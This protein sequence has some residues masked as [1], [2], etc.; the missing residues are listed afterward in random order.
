MLA[1]ILS[2]PRQSFFLLGPRGPTLRT[3]DGIEVLAFQGFT[4]LLAAGDL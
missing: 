4:D 1:R 3:K 2:I